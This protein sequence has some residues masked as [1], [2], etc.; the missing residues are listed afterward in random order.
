MHAAI[1]L[2]AMLAQGRDQ[3][4]VTENEA[5]SLVARPWP[6]STPMVAVC[7]WSATL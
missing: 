7:G 2:E 3:A 5:T 6:T 4:T 1:E